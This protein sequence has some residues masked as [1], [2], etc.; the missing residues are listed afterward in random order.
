MPTNFLQTQSLQS[1]QIILKLDPQS[2]E[3]VDTCIEKYSRPRNCLSSLLFKICEFIRSIFQNSLWQ[4]AQQTLEKALP[5]IFDEATQKSA[6]F[7]QSQS[8]SMKQNLA[9]DILR[10]LIA[11]DREALSFDDL[12]SRCHQ[13]LENSLPSKIIDCRQESNWNMF[14]M[15][16]GLYRPPAEKSVSASNFLHSF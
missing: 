4:K 5:S 11:V 13:T 8:S 15:G 14:L 12:P 16:L 7:F 3:S 1:L 9:N 6:S 10:S 2:L